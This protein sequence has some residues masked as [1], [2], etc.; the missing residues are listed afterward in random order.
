MVKE[1]VFI[2]LIFL[3]LKP[4]IIYLV[5]LKIGIPKD[6]IANIAML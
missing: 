2:E 3:Y 6:N 1:I 4:S 5:A